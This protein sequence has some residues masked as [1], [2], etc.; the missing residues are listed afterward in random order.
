MASGL[1]KVMLNSVQNMITNKLQIL[2][3]VQDDL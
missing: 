3:Q 1:I 2:D